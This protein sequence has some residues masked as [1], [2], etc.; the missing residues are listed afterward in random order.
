MVAE[1]AT[2][3]WRSAPSLT[4][5]AESLLAE[6]V[7]RLGVVLR[8]RLVGSFMETDVEVAAVGTLTPE[9]EALFD[10]LFRVGAG[11]VREHTI[12]N[13][14]AWFFWSTDEELA[15]FENPYQPLWQLYQLG[16][17]TAGG[18]DEVG[19]GMEMTLG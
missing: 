13:L 6:H 7:R 19:S 16:F 15:R 18:I 11:P 10:G 4:L 1:V 8:A 14:H 2:V 5:E 9:S 3:Q 17:T 12:L